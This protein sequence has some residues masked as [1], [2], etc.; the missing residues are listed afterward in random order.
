VE[1][2]FVEHN[3]QLMPCSASDRFVERT[4]YCSSFKKQLM[5]CFSPPAAVEKLDPAFELQGHVG[6][7][8]I[9]VTGFR[10]KK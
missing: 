3:K 5:P 9:C 2:L 4:I 1:T 7:V 6:R 8:E 10:K